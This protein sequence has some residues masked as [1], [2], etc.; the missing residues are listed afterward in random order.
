MSNNNNIEILLRNKIQ[1]LG[2]FL[3]TICNNDTKK[4]EIQDTLIAL[5]FY[6]ILIFISFLDKDKFNH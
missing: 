5:P 4:K 2:N 1:D 6:K 3:L